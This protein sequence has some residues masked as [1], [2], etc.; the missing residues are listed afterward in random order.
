MN[1]E[2]L[3]KSKWGHL[4]RVQQLLDGGAKIET[5]NSVGNTALLL[6]IANSREPVARLLIERGANINVQNKKRETPLYVAIKVGLAPIIGVLLERG[7]DPNVAA[8]EKNETPIH[9]ATKMGDLATVQLLLERGVDINSRDNYG[10]TPLM[11]G[12]SNEAMVRLL[13]ERGADVNAQSDQK[14]TALL[15]A[16]TGKLDNIAGILL[17]AGA[18][19]NHKGYLGSSAIHMAVS[20]KKPATV[21]FLLERGADVNIKDDQNRAPLHIACSNIA[22]KIAKLLIEKGADIDAKDNVGATPLH[23]VVN[24]RGYSVFQLLLKKGANVNIA[25]NAGLTPMH[26][27]VL[28]S[29]QY[30]IGTLRNAHANINAQDVHGNTP[31]Y[32]ACIKGYFDIVDKLIE[33]GADFRK[34][35]AGSTPLHAAC[36]GNHVVTVMKLLENGADIH[37]QDNLGRTPLFGAVEVRDMYIVQTL[38]DRGADI[39]I[40]TTNGNTALHIAARKDYIDIARLLIDRGAD[41]TIQNNAGNTAMDV[42]TTEAMRELFGP[43]KLWAGFSQTDMGLFRRILEDPTNVSVCP[44]C[45]NY[46]ERDKGCMYMAHKCDVDARHPG[47]F[48]KYENHARPPHPIEWCTLCGRAS[49]FHRH[50]TRVSADAPKPPYAPGSQILGQEQ[51]FQDDCRPVGGGGIREKVRRFYRLIERAIALQAEV[52]KAPHHAIRQ[53]LIEDVWNAA[54]DETI[55]VDAILAEKKFPFEGLDVV[56]PEEIAVVAYPDVRRPADEAELTPIRHDGVANAAIGAGQAAGND[57]VIELGPH[58]DNRPVYQFRHKQPDGSI[59]EHKD[60]YICGPDLQ[61]L[62]DDP[63]KGIQTMCP[64]N[65]DKCKAKLYPEEIRNI[66][67]PEFFERYRTQFNR[68][69]RIQ[70]GGSRDSSILQPVD[71]SQ[72]SCSLPSR[73]GRKT[74]RRKRNI[75]KQTFRRRQFSHRR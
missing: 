33:N 44:I 71:L 42:A 52:G 29:S 75:K 13:L 34:N 10:F 55:P 54:S 14:N 17:D 24:N 40:K 73:G 15:L 19:I 28:T 16:T 72:A 41:K 59:Y 61:Q 22:L 36:F 38:L 32:L 27:A 5:K 48:Q 43:P 47:L 58:A 35:N 46:V 31:L 57:C 56:F 39:N 6:A 1:A 37:V 20:Y 63:G 60:E 9:L 66:V 64:I 21:L 7:A 65:I 70:A 51:H 26:S 68:V 12:V 62:L 25:D 4:D 67:D 18:D 23:I 69:H 8:G 2:L 3:K 49:E 50:F 11:Q 53:K 45:L 30:Y 74:P